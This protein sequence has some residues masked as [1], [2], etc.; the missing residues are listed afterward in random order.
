M[1]GNSFGTIFKVTTFGES[2]GVAMGAIIDGCP[3]NIEISEKDIQKELDKRKPGQSAYVTQRN[4]SDAVEILSGVFEGK[5]TGTPIGLVVKNQDQRSKDYE[6]IKDKF[7]PG[8]ADFTYF[9]KYGIRDYRGGGRASARETVMRVA[10]GAIAKKTLRMFGIEVFGGVVQIGQICADSINLDDVYSNSFFF[11]DKS[12][13]SELEQF[14]K[15]LMEAQD[16]IGAKI[17]IKV[18]GVGP[19]LGAPVF[20]KIDAEL[21][22]AVMSVNA[23]KA[24]EIGVGADVVTMRGSENNDEISKEG[25]K[26]NNSGGILGGIS[27]GEDID[28]FASIK[29]TSSISKN[30]KT[31]DIKNEEVDIAIKGRH[32]PCVGLRATPILESMVAITVLDQHLVDRAQCGDV[33]RD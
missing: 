4:E 6:N 11:T 1:S 26:T 2:H 22:K 24:F 23:V 33:K 8:H 32:D 19:G 13:I 9:K 16:S 28:V 31:V 15:N 3:P 30:S 18:K 21:A 29:P 14:F 27:N 5:T 7:R 25:F 12:K 17:L 10:A 20:S